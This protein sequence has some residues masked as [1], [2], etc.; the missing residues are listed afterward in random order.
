MPFQKSLEYKDFNYKCIYHNE[1]L[2]SEKEKIKTMYK[3][4]HKKFL[5]DLGCEDKTSEIYQQFIDIDWI[6][7]EYF[8]NSSHAEQVRDYMAGM[9]DRYFERVFEE[10]MIPK[11][12]TSFKEL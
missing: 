5:E 4:M 6:S 10:I 7:K 12:V 11:R 3:I 2:S 8:E 9:T 1:K